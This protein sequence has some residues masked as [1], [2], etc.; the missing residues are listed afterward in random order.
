M[1]NNNIEGVGINNNSEKNDSNIKEGL[2]YKGTEFWK[3]ELK[4]MGIEVNASNIIV[5][6]KTQPSPEYGEPIKKNVQAN[7]K[8][9]DIYRLGN[10]LFLHVKE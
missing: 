9:V 3:E 8:M 6:E 2:K 5:I 1:N 10:E 7:G 4:K